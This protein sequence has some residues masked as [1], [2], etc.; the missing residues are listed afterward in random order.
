MIF[1]V[2]HDISEDELRSVASSTPGYVGGDLHNVI[3][4]AVM[5][6][7][8]RKLQKQDLDYAVTVTKP[9]ALKD[10]SYVDHKVGSDLYF[11]NSYFIL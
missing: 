9:A 2:P 6:S 7:E 3:L 10:S 8:D 11:C 1:R 5:H 4:E